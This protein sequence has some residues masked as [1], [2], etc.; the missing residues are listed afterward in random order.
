MP[1]RLFQHL[2]AAFQ[3]PKAD[4]FHGPFDLLHLMHEFS[5]PVSNHPNMVVTVH[6]LGPLLYPAYFQKDYRLKWKT[7]LDRTVDCASRV[8]AV[9]ESLAGQLR[10]YRSG[11]SH[12]IHSTPL[13]VA[14][15]FF[16]QTSEASNRNFTSQSG[17]GY[18]YI[19]YT[20][21]FDEGKNI[22]TLLEAFSL[23]LN[24]PGSA[25]PFHLVLVGN[26][27]WGGYDEL[28]EKA[29][30][31]KIDSK[32]HFLDYIDHSALPIFYRRCS[33]FVFPSLFEG[34]GLPV[35]EAMACGAPCLISNRPA[36]D[37]LGKEIA[38]YFDPTSPADLAEKLLYLLDDGEKL[39]EMSRKGRLHAKEYTWKNTAL[40][41][42][43]VY[44]SVL[45]VEL[46]AGGKT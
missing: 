37:E 10:R 20:G 43:G 1:G 38:V 33:L 25:K 12:K 13:G 30:E 31:L 40:E 45:G 44:E 32:T 2:N 21:A 18:P 26:S 8:I 14:D 39:A 23:Y 22:S 17:I 36:L 41:T 27:H 35:L 6:G 7:D 15:V 19:L 24:E 3:W 34:F 11:I 9:S 46:I 4:S 28:R 42:I 16:A 5:A 29:A